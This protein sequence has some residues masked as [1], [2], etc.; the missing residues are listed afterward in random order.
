MANELELLDSTG[1][2]LL[3]ASRLFVDS[4]VR[5]DNSLPH[6]IYVR[7]VYKVHYVHVFVIRSLQKREMERSSAAEGAA[8]VYY[9]NWPHLTRS[10][11]KRSRCRCRS[12]WWWR[13]CCETHWRATRCAGEC[14]CSATTAARV[15]SRRPAT[16]R[17]AR[18][19]ATASWCAPSCASCSARSA[20]RAATSHTPPPTARTTR[21]ARV[22]AHAP[23]PAPPLSS[24]RSPTAA[25]PLQ[26]G[27][28]A[29]FL[30]NSSLRHKVYLICMH[31]TTVI[32]LICYFNH[33]G[34]NHTV[35]LTVLSV[36]YNVHHACAQYC[37]IILSIIISVHLNT[38]LFISIITNQ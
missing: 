25:E 37:T 30:T 13:R 21:T 17:T 20:A 2:E 15:S 36:L 22:P 23:P 1:G 7:L 8:T 14:R 12:S 5:A 6:P 31:V 11:N 19:T 27:R 18:A 16:S 4:S 32:C 9:S 29:H 34:T 33:A 24:V 10:V 38:H 35:P 26:S 28:A 3:Q